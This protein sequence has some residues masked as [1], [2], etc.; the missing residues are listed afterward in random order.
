MS[1][2][3]VGTSGVF[4]PGPL[5]TPQQ[6]NKF[7]QKIYDP[8]FKVAGSGMYFSN[9][10]EAKTSVGEQVGEQ[11][12]RIVKQFNKEYYYVMAVQDTD[13]VFF[14]IYHGGKISFWL[15]KLYGENPNYAKA[16]IG[17]SKPSSIKAQLFK[18][19]SPSTA[20]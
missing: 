1:K 11:V 20:F 9:A 19:D 13:E 7:A 18:P 5:L 12:G 16:P 14:K 6:A 17:T 2:S 8:A 3:N 4:T 15:H 10:D